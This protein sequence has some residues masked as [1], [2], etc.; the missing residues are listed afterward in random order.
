VTGK[1]GDTVAA[2]PVVLGDA[3][4]FVV[5]ILQ[6][7]AA[8]SMRVFRSAVGRRGLDLRGSGFV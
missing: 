3:Q 5:Q 4:G 6:A 7:G 1:V 2:A 8:C